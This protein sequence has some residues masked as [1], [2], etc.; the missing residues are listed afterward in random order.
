MTISEYSA[1]KERYSKISGQRT[2]YLQAVDNHFLSLAENEGP[3]WLDIGSG[4]GVRALLLNEKLKK[5]LSVI[6]PSEL[7]PRTFE[8]S[9]PEVQVIRRRVEDLEFEREFDIVTMLWNVIGHLESLKDCLRFIRKSLKPHG[10]L[11]FD[12][13]SAL[14]LRRFG[15]ADVARNLLHTQ[16]VKYPWPNP[17][18]ETFVEIFR[19]S[20]LERA[21]KEAG[22]Q[23]E[24]RYLDYDRGEW[25]QNQFQGSFIILARRML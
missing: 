6:E 23:V 1:L 3:D 25:V 16:S 11:Y 21:L 15:A 22:F 19:K 17:D 9:N 14:N 10:L 4:D 2:T 5:N 13:N 8:R 12:S 18:S 24:V 7:L 20:F